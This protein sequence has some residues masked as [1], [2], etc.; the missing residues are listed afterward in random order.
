MCNLENDCEVRSVVLSQ[1]V[2]DGPDS[3]AG[4]EA[5]SV[6]IL[7]T[8]IFEEKNMLF[9]EITILQVAQNLPTEHD[10]EATKFIA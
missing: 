10:R 5:V 2:L 8:E 9:S 6:R 3:L 7:D 4:D 1:V